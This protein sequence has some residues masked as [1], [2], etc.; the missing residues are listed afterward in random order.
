MSSLLVPPALRPWVAGVDVATADHSVAVD[1]PDHASTLLL[2][3]DRRELVALGP[4]T[5]ASYHLG[6]AGHS[7]VR[8]RLRPGRALALFGRRPGEL[9]DRALPL[10]ALPGLDLDRLAT[11][12][13]GALTA[14][15]AD[16]PPPSGQLDVAARLLADA[17]PVAAVAARLRLGER[18]LRALFTEATG[19]S[20]KRFARIDRLRAVLAAEAGRWS[21]IAVAAGY[22]DQSHLTA[23]FRHFMGV[24]PAAFTA[25]RRPAADRCV[26]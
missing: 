10:D 5:R 21:E 14:A 9:T 13:T 25:G 19:L 12:P 20:P 7:C 4:R 15:L 1:L 23:E 17:T 3:R 26:P 2:R 6:A 11:D 22:Y 16:R 8:V 24:P 18:R